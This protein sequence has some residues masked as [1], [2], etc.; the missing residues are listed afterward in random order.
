[1]KLKNIVFAYIIKAMSNNRLRGLKPKL[2][3]P[4]PVRKDLTPKS[5]KYSPKISP[6][7]SSIRQ[8]ISLKPDPNSK[9]KIT[10]PS[11]SKNTSES[12]NFF[13]SKDNNTNVN[14]VTM[15]NDTKKYYTSSSSKRVE[16]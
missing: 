9:I 16:V 7:Y 12:K 11:T 8:G 13:H 10:R 15:S 5:N 6:V 4:T 2:E 14:T 1:M 3:D